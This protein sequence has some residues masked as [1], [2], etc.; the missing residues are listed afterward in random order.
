MELKSQVLDKSSA[1]A[2]K[3]SRIMA[4]D[5]RPVEGSTRKKMRQVLRWFVKEKESCILEHPGV[6]GRFL[7]THM[8][9]SQC[10]LPWT[11]DHFR[12]SKS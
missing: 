9:S 2:L 5:R 12:F 4:A 11:N 3:F 7:F 6:S 10:F 8:Y 1:R